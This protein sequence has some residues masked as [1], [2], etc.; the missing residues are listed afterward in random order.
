MTADATRWPVTW[1][2]Q[3]DLPANR[4]VRIVVEMSQAKLFSITSGQ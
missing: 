3:G 1:H 4:L 2:K